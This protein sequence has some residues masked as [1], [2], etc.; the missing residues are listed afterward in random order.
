M[1]GIIGNA[2]EYK[3]KKGRKKFAISQFHARMDKLKRNLR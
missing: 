2:P 1:T 3:S